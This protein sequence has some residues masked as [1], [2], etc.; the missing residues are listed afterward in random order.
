MDISI[1]AIQK[2]L[3]VVD[4]QFPPLRTL[5]NY[6][7]FDHSFCYVL[8]VVKRKNYKYFDTLTR[9]REMNLND[10]TD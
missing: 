9:E 3:Y 8:K 4:E 7:Y 2:V 10:Q 5:K 1:V 6:K